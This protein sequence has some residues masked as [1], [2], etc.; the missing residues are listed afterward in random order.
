MLS[1]TKQNKVK[2]KKALFKAGFTLFIKVKEKKKKR[3]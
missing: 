2:K 1:K 3:N